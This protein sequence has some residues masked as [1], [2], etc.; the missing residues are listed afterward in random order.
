MRGGFLDLTIGTSALFTAQTALSVTSNNISNANTT[1]YSRRVTIQQATRAL[2][3][4]GRGML[5]TGVDV[6][7]IRRVR[8]YYVDVKYRNQNTS[9]AE[10]NTFAKELSQIDKL[11]NEPTD[12]GVNKVIDNFFESFQS[13][14]TNTSNISYFEN[15]KQTAQ[16]MVSF[17]HDMYTTLQEQ[18]KEIDREIQGKINTVNSIANQIRVVNEQIY[19]IESNGDLANDLRDR[20]DLLVD[21]LSQIV[22]VEVEEIEKNID[23]Q[24]GA[25]SIQER[26]SSNCIFIVTING[27][28]LVNHTQ[29]NE[30][31]V[32]QTNSKNNPEDAM[33]PYDI[34]WKNGMPFNEY[35]ANLKGELKALVQLRDGNF[36]NVFSGNVSGVDDTLRTLTVKNVSRAD[37]MEP[38]V[39]RIGSATYEYDSYQYNEATGEVTFNLA[40]SVANPIPISTG[41]K[42]EV[43]IKVPYKGIPYYMNKLN[44][45]VRT[46]ARAIN[47]GTYRDGSKIEGMTGTMN[48]YTQSSK[49][50]V[51]LFAYLNMGSVLGSG[52]V[53][54][55]EK[56][57]AGNFSLS[58]DLLED[59]RNIPT[60]TS[61]NPK[62]S[63]AEIIHEILSLKHNNKLFKQGALLD[64]ISAM[65]SEVGSDV[66]SSKNFTEI[67]ENIV[68]YL[69]N[70]RLSVSGVEL[71]EEMT[72]LV[73]YQSAYTAAAKLIN[74][75]DQI[76]DVTINGLM[77]S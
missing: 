2:P 45:F 24:G 58:R 48:G 4:A 23:L 22:N 11:F 9:F 55:Y 15:A 5:G 44:E 66:S 69:Q 65:M 14:S 38:G 28:E 64:Y 68:N 33:H 71:N 1:G 27:Q 42:V 51:P 76:Y 19:K 32:V 72:N 35:S 29:V 10:Y 40:A 61:I 57:T 39:I 3:G 46:F 21:Q 13:L 36:N 73:K 6:I 75:V 34:Q 30:L 12:E 16:T 50:G 31:T 53:I 41:A 20:R 52:D 77:S 37:L 18:Q 8:D 59:A 26:R 47:E 49:T 60:S 56:M 43:G 7:D 70:Q 17:I 54:D 62:E 67:Q 74:I 63:Q 25:N